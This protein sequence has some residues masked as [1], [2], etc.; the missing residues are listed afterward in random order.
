MRGQ[1]YFGDGV[2]APVKLNSGNRLL[3]QSPIDSL[4]RRERE[5]L[6]L[7]AEGKTNA[8]IAEFI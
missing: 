7:V 4:S 8:I 6:Q 2:E 5:T 1:H 3:S